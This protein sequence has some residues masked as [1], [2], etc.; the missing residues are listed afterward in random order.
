MRGLAELLTTL[1]AANES[2]NFCLSDAPLPGAVCSS[3][4]RVMKL[5]S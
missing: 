1:A 4:L 5:G 2:I 3:V